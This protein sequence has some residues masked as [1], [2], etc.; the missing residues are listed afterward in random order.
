V[1]AA[2]ARIRL[3]ELPERPPADGGLPV[4]AGARLGPDGR[5][6]LWLSTFVPW[7]PASGPWD[8]PS[9]QRAPDHVWR[10]AEKALGTALEPVDGVSPA[11]SN[12][13]RGTA[14]RTASST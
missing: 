14:A 7:R 5:A 3:G 13:S 2:F 10:V 6:A 1:E 8:G 12:G 11:R 4:H 9:L